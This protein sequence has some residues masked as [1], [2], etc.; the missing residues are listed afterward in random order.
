M[1][2]LKYS[3][4]SDQVQTIIADDHAMVRSGLRMLTSAI[5]PLVVVAEVS[6]GSELV[7]YVKNNQVDLVL[8]DISMPVMDGIAAIESIRSFNR[9]I[10]I[11]ALS[12]Y[13]SAE[14]IKRAVRAG[15]DG[16]VLKN[17]PTHELEYA[18][19]AV[20]IGAG[21]YSTE[22][23]KKLAEE[24][25]PDPRDVLTERQMEILRL[26][27]RGQSSKEIGFELGLSPKTVDVHRAAIM[28]R[29]KVNDLASLTLYAVRFGI[30]D[31]VSEKSSSR[32]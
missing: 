21:Y 11:I 23:S 1:T 28:A 6:N 14:F 26:L 7:E 10:K 8:T 19:K 2:E 15:A 20:L 5:S 13:D 27:V 32:R 25:E 30:V 9:S 12:M 3:K 18:I 29:L 16:Y 24:T 22:V 4:Y 17:A 31:P